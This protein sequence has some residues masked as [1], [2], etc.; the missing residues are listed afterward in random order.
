MFR[1]LLSMPNNLKNMVRYNSKLNNI[2]PITVT[3]TAWNK[4]NDILKKSDSIG[5][6][7]SIKSGGCNGFNYKF[8]VLNEKNSDILKEKIKPNVIEKDNCKV[9]IDPMAEMYLIGTQI[10]YIE[11]NYE[12]GIY[13]SKFIYKADKDIATNCGCGISFSPKV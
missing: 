8:E 9:Y 3:D 7:F 12:K 2:L 6:L 13:E 11:E 1:T 5:M 4:I 10:D